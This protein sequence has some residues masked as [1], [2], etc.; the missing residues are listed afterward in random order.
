MRWT[1]GHFWKAFTYTSEL[2]Q[3]FSYKYAI[4]DSNTW[5]VRQWEEGG[6]RECSLTAVEGEVLNR[7]SEPFFKQNDPCR[8]KVG[9]LNAVYVK[10]KKHLIIQDKWN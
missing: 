7:Q 8:L 3:T 4:E 6:N 9:A 5:E 1:E 10:D 2:P